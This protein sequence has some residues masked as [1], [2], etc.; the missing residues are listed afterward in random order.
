MVG[1]S[2]L[3]YFYCKTGPQPVPEEVN[4]SDILEENYM[5]VVTGDIFGSG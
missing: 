5:A 2:S 4:D 3:K 1:V